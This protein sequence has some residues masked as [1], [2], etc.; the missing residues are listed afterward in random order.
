MLLTFA[1]VL[2]QDQLKSV[3]DSLKSEDFVDGRKTAG[4]HAKLVKNNLQLQSGEERTKA[5]QKIC[6]DAILASAEFHRAY[7]PKFVR[8]PMISRYDVG[9]SYGAH[10]DDPFMGSN[11]I[12][13]TDV[14]ATLFLADPSTY[15]GGELVIEG[16]YGTRS[17]KLDAGAMVAY[18]ATTLHHVAPVTSG[19]RI[20]AVTWAQSLIPDPSHREIIFELDNARRMIFE[21]EGKS[22]AFDLV[23]KSHANLMRMWSDL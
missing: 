16:T 19:A 21:K 17:V 23:S 1:N 9:M 18:P 8:P 4:W 20:A 11:P 13:R 2:S 6:H 7:K 3:V 12:M 15:E 10:V 14:A 22:P 5:L